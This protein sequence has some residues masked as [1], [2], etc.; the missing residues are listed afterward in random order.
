MPA[1]AAAPVDVTILICTYNRAD[2]LEAMLASLAALVI[3]PGLAVELVVVDNNSTDR[4]R[5]VCEAARTPVPLRYIFEAQQ[6]QNP[7][8]NRGLAETSGRLILF[9]DD[10]V[11][12]DAGWLAAYGA[13]AAR[14]PAAAYFGGRTL[15]RWE[16][17]PPRWFAE[18]STT[19]LA[20][21]EVY[22]DAGLEEK[23]LP[24]G[25]A[26]AN[27]A[28]RRAALH[29]LAFDP[30]LGP[31]GTETVRCGEVELIGQIR[32]RGGGGMHVPG[33]LIHH[34]TPARRM[35][36]A[37][38]RQWFKGDGIAEVRRQQVVRTNPWFG[39]SR[40]YWKQWALSALKYG[41]TRWL[42]PASVWL[43]AEID[44]ARAWGVIAEC[45]RQAA[46]RRAS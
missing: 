46:A 45:R 16:A 42:G 38:V 23:P 43:P 22:S 2:S 24:A 18:H 3:P 14:W 12:V 20:C 34:R 36:E 32:Q 44:M 41:C 33:A 6:G 13:A 17:A 37:Y 10:D 40:Y 5:A 29:G 28:I 39:V 26:G 35:T 11:D 7:A 25:V 21:I 1:A 19:H 9:T 15:P 30:A 8:L 27:M 31:D 4:T